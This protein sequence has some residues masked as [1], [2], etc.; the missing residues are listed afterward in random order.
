MIPQPNANDPTGVVIR[1]S[2]DSKNPVHL[3]R[4]HKCYV[5][6]DGWSNVLP[7]PCEEGLTSKLSGVNVIDGFFEAWVKKNS[8]IGEELSKTFS[9]MRVYKTLEHGLGYFS[10]DIYAYDGEGDIDWGRDESGKLMP[11]IRLV[12]TLSADLSG[13]RRFLKVQ[14]GPEGQDFWTVWYS[15]KVHFGGTALKAKMTWEERVSISHF[16]P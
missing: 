9:Y 11:K 4:K 16:H 6:V 10:L 5:D 15:I 14:K 8:V 7:I 2:F 1:R 12:C 13:L 3:R